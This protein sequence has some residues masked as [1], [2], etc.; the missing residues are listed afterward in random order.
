[1]SLA[2]AWLQYLHSAGVAHRDL[3][4]SNI[5]VNKDRPPMNRRELREP[6]KTIP[7]RTVL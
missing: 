4:P 3:K 2:F 7:G 1:M 5:L 6:E